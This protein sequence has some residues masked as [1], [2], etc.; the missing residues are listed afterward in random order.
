MDE[1]RDIN[2]EK[3]IKVVTTN[4]FITSCGLDKI[5]L[6]ARK[7]LYIAIAQCKLSDNKF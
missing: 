7:L 1:K 6:K 2:T 4:D 3:C 5:S